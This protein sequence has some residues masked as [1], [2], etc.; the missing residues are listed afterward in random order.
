M[1]T[2]F[3]QQNYCTT[4]VVSLNFSN[5]YLWVK[6]AFSNAALE[7]IIDELTIIN[8]QRQEPHFY[9]TYKMNKLNHSLFCCC[10]YLRDLKS[11]QSHFNDCIQ[12]YNISAFPKQTEKH[13]RHIQSNRKK[14]KSFPNVVTYLH[15][16]FMNPVTSPHRM[17]VCIYQT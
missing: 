17:C 16:K 12:G 1:S 13:F 15:C 11:V 2:Y 9:Q 3:W 4:L 8:F 7:K 14:P 10:Q 5:F 6:T